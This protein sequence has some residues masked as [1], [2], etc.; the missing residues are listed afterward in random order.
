MKSGELGG[1]WYLFLIYS[2]SLCAVRNCLLFLQLKSATFMVVLIQITVVLEFGVIIIH[3]TRLPIVFSLF[4]VV[5]IAENNC[6]VLQWY[7]RNSMSN[8]TY[9][10]ATLKTRPTVAK[11]R[12][13][14]CR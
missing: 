8:R 10:N 9:V 11:T 5:D 2:Y 12:K 3:P 6:N 1:G 7:A 14:L 4:G 13:V